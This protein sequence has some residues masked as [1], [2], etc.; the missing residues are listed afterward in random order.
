MKI[1]ITGVTGFIGQNLLPQIS[2]EYPNVQVMTLNRDVEKAAIMY[3]VALYPN[4]VHIS[5]SDK[6]CIIDFDPEIVIHLAALNTS[7]NDSEIIKPLIDANIIFGIYL[8]D[9]L[10][11]CKSLKLFVNTGSF[12]E[13]RLNVRH[14]NSACLYAATK[15]AFKT[16]LAYYAD[17]CDFN[18]LTAVPYSVYGGN[19]TLK[20]MMDFL[21]ESMDS[22]IPVDMT[23]GEQVLDFI[24]IEDIS[25]FYLHVIDNL[26]VFIDLDKGE[27]FYL[28]T[29][30][31]TSIHELSVLMEQISGKHCNINWGACPYRVRDVMYAVA[32]IAK[33][34]ELVGWK[35]HIDLK[36]GL[37][38]LIDKYAKNK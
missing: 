13:Y 30:R 10:S 15:T 8:L 24:H 25:S 7:R 9:A 38:K 17:M 4:I 27:E 33:N 37:V 23:L 12:S 35:A 34:V 31:G 14:A 1:L 21:L 3:P 29:G 6:Q 26:S 16:F 36:E 5:V 28:G 2:K 18:Y 32:P 19:R 22:S 20:R 11:H